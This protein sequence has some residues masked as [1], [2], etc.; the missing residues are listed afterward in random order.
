MR[1][2]QRQRKRIQ[3]DDSILTLPFRGARTTC[4]I[5][6]G[7]RKSCEKSRELT[8]L[9][10]S[11]HVRSMSSH[12]RHPIS[13]LQRAGPTVRGLGTE[14]VA[15]GSSSTPH[16]RRIIFSGIQPTGVP[17]IGN[18]LG[19]LSQWQKLVKEAAAQPASARDALYFS[20]V[21]LHALTVPQVSTTLMRLEPSST[22]LFRIPSDCDRNA[23]ICLPSC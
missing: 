12:L 5:D 23:E 4:M 21:G 9:V 14:A 3:G 11:T 13:K 20:V 22:L 6:T 15:A 1:E 17:H 16:K 18:H 8:T 7:E 2:L 10:Q 19:A